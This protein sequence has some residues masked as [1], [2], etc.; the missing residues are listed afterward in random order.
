MTY[1]EY[2]WEAENDHSKTEALSY[3][4]PSKLIFDG[5]GMTPSNR[6]GIWNDTAG[7]LV[8]FNASVWHGKRAGRPPLRPMRR[9]ARNRPPGRV[10]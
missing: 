9:L 1:V 6:E 3:S 10:P 7:N 5:M 4:R 8:C 2:L